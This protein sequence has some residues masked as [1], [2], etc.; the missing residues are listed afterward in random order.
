MDLIIRFKKPSGYL[1]WWMLIIYKFI[2]LTGYSPT[3]F[4]S[5]N[6]A[7]LKDKDQLNRLKKELADE[8][9]KVQQLTAQLSTNV[10]SQHKN[11][12]CWWCSSSLQTTYNKIV[13]YFQSHVVSA[14]EHSLSNMTTRLAKL[15]KET[16]R[17]VRVTSQPFPLLFILVRS[18][19]LAIGIMSCLTTY[20]GSESL[21][22]L[23]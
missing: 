6:S 21:F 4:N 3:F 23:D 11:Y 18:I 1:K 12:T 17:K 14:F 16:E 22:S 7:P 10:S 2:L 20:L 5:T 15:N 8:Q 19:N 13:P 9:E